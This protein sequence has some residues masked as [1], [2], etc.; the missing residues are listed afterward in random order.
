[1]LGA[2]PLVLILA[3]AAPVGADE[4]PFSRF[5]IAG[6]VSPFDNASSVEVADF[7]GDGD[8]DVLAAAEAEGPGFGEVSWWE[9]TAG[10]GS[11]WTKNIINGA[12]V[13]QTRKASAADFDGDGDMDVIVIT[14]WFQDII[15][16]L[17]SDG[18]GTSWT[19]VTVDDNVPF[20]C[21]A[22][23]ADVD[24]DGDIDIIGGGKRASHVL[25]WW[26]NDGSA[27]N[28]WIEHT[29]QANFT[30]PCSVAAADVDKDGLLD[31]F[32]GAE[33]LDRVS[34]FKNPGSGGGTW[35]ETQVSTTAIDGVRSVDAG[36]YDGDG[37][38]DV[39]AA[40]RAISDVFWFEN[41]AGDGS[42]WTEHLIDDDM[43]EAW[44][45]HSADVDEDGD[46]DLLVAA[47]TETPPNPQGA[48][49]MF[50]NEDGD[51]S[52]WTRR[53][54]DG[55]LSTPQSVFTGDVDGDGR[56]DV[57]TA[58]GGDRVSWFENIS[59][60]RS[61]AWPDIRPVDVDFDGAR[62]LA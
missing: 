23:A 62:A 25:A 48:V 22:E 13:R 35:S 38:I 55:A 4:Q 45:V 43:N 39:A 32:A 28:P 58:T 46:L 14:E 41:T 24:G 15:V 3:L 49:V 47:R 37:D 8:L 5:D 42:A 29:I 2:A 61:A 27:G 17:N 54:I 18:V 21:V 50:D 31:V 7:D 33:F 57:L 40:A 60:E 10:D 19:Q 51:A 36:D 11:A 59:T 12:V 53:D 26:E 20:T 52:V 56:L 9:N 6:P 44:D 1:M 16:Y 34:W 30:G